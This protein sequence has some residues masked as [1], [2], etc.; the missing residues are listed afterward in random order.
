MK[1]KS[2]VLV[3][4]GALRGK[5]DVPALRL[6]WI[7]AAVLHGDEAAPVHRDVENHIAGRGGT[8]NLVVVRPIGTV[9]EVHRVV[10]I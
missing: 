5:G 6:A 1:R 10:A 8:M 2:E 3:G 4:V 7:M 9:L